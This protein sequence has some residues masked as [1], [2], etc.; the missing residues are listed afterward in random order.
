[1]N[2]IDKIKRDFGFWLSRKI[3]FPLVPPDTLQISLT[4]RCNLRCE[5]CSV[6]KAAN[7]SEELTLKEI[8]D[9]LNQCREW[10][11][12]EVNLCGGEPLLCE[13]CFDVIEYAKSLGLTVILTTNGTLITEEVARRL[14]Q[15]KLD[16]ITI[17]LD[18]ARG[19]THDK[20]RAQPGAY[21][22]IMQGIRHLNNSPEEKKLIKV[23]ILTLSNYN[24]DELE[25]Y[26]HLAKGLSVDALYI[27]SVV[28]NNVKLYKQDSG[29]SEGNL[30]ITGDRLKKLDEMIDK[31]DLLQQKGYGLN[32]PSFYLIKKYFR[33][34]LCEGDWVCFAG[35]RR[36]V[37]VP[38]GSIQ[39]CGEEIGNIRREPSVKN[40]WFSLKAKKRRV[41]IKKCRNYCLQDCHAR[42]ESASLRDILK[43]NFRKQK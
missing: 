22:K 34:D 8:K 33:R 1:M 15:S 24:L 10:G 11:V 42:Q 40:N 43:N 27:T 18:G 29:S 26:F 6:W 30:W 37:V 28:L 5:M 23:L 13:I 7:I 20:I 39:M 3:N 38:G 16:V 14:I 19:K 17:S 21:D 9:I 25:E 41:K 36:F 31:I 35:Y 4:S 2:K 32:Y 12:K